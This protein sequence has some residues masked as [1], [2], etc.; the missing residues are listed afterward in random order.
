MLHKLLWLIVAVLSFVFLFGFSALL[1]N[2]T[3]FSLLAMLL[4]PALQLPSTSGF[5]VL[6]SPF[7]HL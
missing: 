1:A 3:F 5:R 2:T 6:P 7:H 4:H